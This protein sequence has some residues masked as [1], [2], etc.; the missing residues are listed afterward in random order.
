MNETA[1]VLF[2]SAGTCAV[3]PKGEAYSEEMLAAGER[4]NRSFLFLSPTNPMQ[5]ILISV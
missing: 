5:H 4:E 3:L 2:C 1:V